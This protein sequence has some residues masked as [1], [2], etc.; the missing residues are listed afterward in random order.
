MRLVFLLDSEDD[1]VEAVVSG[2]SVSS[3]FVFLASTFSALTSSL[4]DFPFIKLFYF[5]LA[6][7]GLT[8]SSILA[9]RIPGTGKPGGLS[10]GSHRVGHD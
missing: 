7:L 10:M 6:A 4:P 8:H 1:P 9:W 5:S 3:C 2:S